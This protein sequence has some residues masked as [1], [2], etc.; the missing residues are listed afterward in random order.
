MIP[1][2]GLQRA[3]LGKPLRAV[4]WVFAFSVLNARGRT[5]CTDI[6]PAPGQEH[7]ANP[8]ALS[9]RL[10]HGPVALRFIQKPGDVHG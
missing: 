4:P 8:D 10:G 5:I 9:L 2:H 1:G 6:E 7:A 3:L